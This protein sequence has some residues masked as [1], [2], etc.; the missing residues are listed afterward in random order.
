MVINYGTILFTFAYFATILGLHIKPQRGQLQHGKQTETTTMVLIITRK[1]IKII[2]QQQQDKFYL[3]FRM[4]IIL[5]FIL[6]GILSELTKIAAP[7][8]NNIWIDQFMMI[9][10]GTA[11]D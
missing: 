11:V 6:C 9:V 7:A 10:M 1:M 4:A 8:S 2:L 5:V 3:L